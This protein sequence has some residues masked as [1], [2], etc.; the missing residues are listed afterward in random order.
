MCL[1]F[2]ASFR[3]KL[4]IDRGHIKLSRIE[5]Q[6]TVKIRGRGGRFRMGLRMMG[7]VGVVM[8]INRRAFRSAPP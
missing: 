3:F 2:R 1:P 5:L 4:K 8:A 6:N 7:I